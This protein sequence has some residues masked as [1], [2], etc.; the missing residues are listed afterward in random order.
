MSDE[1]KKMIE[2]A[3]KFLGDAVKTGA[4]FAGE[5]V[6]LII[7]EKLAYDFWYYALCSL[8]WGLLWIIPFLAYR[9]CWACYQKDRSSAYDEG[10]IVFAIISGCLAV[11]ISEMLKITLAPRLYIMEWAASLLNQGK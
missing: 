4:E 6:P 3:L 5:E 1:M 2:E 9:K 11:N 7:Q 10:A 8:V